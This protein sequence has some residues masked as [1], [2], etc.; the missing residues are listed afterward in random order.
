MMSNVLEP[1]VPICDAIAL[2]FRPHVEVVLHDLTTQTIFYIANSYSKRRAGDSSLNEPEPAFDSS[3]D[4]IGPY[5]KRNW[6][7]RRLKSITAVI[8]DLDGKPIGLLCINQDIEAFSG[9]LEQLGQ[10]IE[11]P[12][13]S[14]LPSALFSSDW[15]EGVNTIVSEFLAARNVALA[16]LTGDD[17]HDL[18]MELDRHGIFQIRK[19]VPYVAE[20]LGLSRATI[21]NHLGSTRHRV[22]KEE[23]EATL[24]LD[25]AE[26]PIGGRE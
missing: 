1:Y 24:P 8:R 2:L 9:A 17:C 26:V 6:D 23:G 22:A 12:K 5:G 14:P 10:L 16:G 13:P 4:V 20:V 11:L 19:A 7:G 21:Y 18:V 3:A 25:D 15:R